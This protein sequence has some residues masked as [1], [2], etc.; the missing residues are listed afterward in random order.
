MHR[1][2]GHS[3]AGRGR[4]FRVYR[5]VPAAGVR[6]I[7]LPH[8][9]G[10]ASFYRNWSSC[11]SSSVEVVAVQP[12]G[13]EERIGEPM[14]ATMDSLVE[15]LADSMPHVADRPYLL[16]GHSMGAAVAHELCLALRRRGRRLPVHLVV[17]GREAPSR[18]RGGSLHRGGDAQLRDELKRLNGTAAE[19]M[20][21]PD[22][23]AMALP[24]IR[25]DYRLIETYRPHAAAPLDIP[26]TA[27]A[28][29]Q[30]GELLPGDAEAWAEQT[31][32]AFNLHRFPG[33]HFYLTAQRAGVVQ[34]LQ[35]LLD[36]V[37]S[38]APV[39]LSMP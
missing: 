5:P 6:L 28:G 13:R 10:A 1:V 16:F 22:W 21:S 31:R 3:A 2:T 23:C 7:C 25:N 32:A 39:L 36:T 4:W 29:E 12:P 33:D 24:I 35:R 9:G 14:L 20:D 18:H 37:V 27:V 11:F 19:L 26:I 17:S 34:V 15:A 38:C 30:D 8:A